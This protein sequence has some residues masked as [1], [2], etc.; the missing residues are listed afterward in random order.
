[1]QF[2]RT[3]L[4]TLTFSTLAIA[5]DPL[6]GRWKMNPEKSTAENIPKTKSA[7]LLGATR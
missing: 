4:A 6:V 1:M 7:T 3:A 2:R 5:A